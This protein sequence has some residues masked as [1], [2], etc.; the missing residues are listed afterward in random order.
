MG[1]SDLENI[2]WIP[3]NDSLSGSFGE[4]RRFSS[5]RAYHDSGSFEESETA[6]D[7]RLIGRSVWNTQWMMVIPGGTLLYDGDDGLDTFIYGQ[8]VPGKEELLKTA[9]CQADELKCRDGLGVS[10][11]KLFFS[12]YGYSGY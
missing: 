12:T 8:P 3:N 5:Y 1:A 4:I 6:R 11:I 2:D 10:D 7:S 9:E